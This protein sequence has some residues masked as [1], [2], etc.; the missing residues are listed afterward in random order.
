MEN[1]DASLHGAVKKMAEPR[2]RKMMD[3]MKDRI[4]FPQ[5]DIPLHSYFFTAPEFV[6]NSVLKKPFKK[7]PDT[8][9]SEF[10]RRIEESLKKIDESN[11]SGDKINRNIS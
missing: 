7:I 6:E 1:I 11:F 3:V 4:R 5:K 2:L 9:P 10:Y 8:K